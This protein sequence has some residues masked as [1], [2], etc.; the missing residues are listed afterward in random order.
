MMKNRLFNRLKASAGN[1]GLQCY[2]S[3][4]KFSRDARPGLIFPFDENQQ[5]WYINKKTYLYRLKNGRFYQIVQFSISR[6]I[7]VDRG[8]NYVFPSRFHYSKQIMLMNKKQF[9]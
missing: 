6:L 3:I 9:F 7:I 1:K 8:V 2:I 4:N 5:I